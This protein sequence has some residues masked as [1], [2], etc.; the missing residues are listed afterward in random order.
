MWLDVLPAFAPGLLGM[1][2]GAEILVITW[3]HQA[4][5]DVLEVHPRRN[6][7]N[8]LFVQTVRGVGYRLVITS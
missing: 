4:N 5:R 3:L 1:T 6:P 2:A 7:A 8:P